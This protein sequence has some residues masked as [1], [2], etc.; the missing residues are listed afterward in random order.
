MAPKAKGSGFAQMSVLCEDPANMCTTFGKPVDLGRIDDID[1][2]HVDNVC[3]KSQVI[4]GV[5]GTALLPVTAARA[6]SLV[7]VRIGLEFIER[8][9]SIEACIQCLVRRLLICNKTD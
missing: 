2:N 6:W 3:H 8:A 7:F 4:H 5:I 1:N 9:S